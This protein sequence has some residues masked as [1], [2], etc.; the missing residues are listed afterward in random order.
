MSDPLRIRSGG[1]WISTATATQPLKLKMPNGAWRVF[2][3]GTGTPL[4]QKQ[5]DGSWRVVAREGF[6]ADV[7]VPATSYTFQPGNWT[8]ADR[9]LFATANQSGSTFFDTSFLRTS[10]G[11]VYYLLKETGTTNENSQYTT[12]TKRM[13]HGYFDLRQLFDVN[14][15]GQPV[16]FPSL[17]SGVEFPYESWTQVD[18]TVTGTASYYYD[19]KRAVGLNVYD[20]RDPGTDAAWSALEHT[21]TRVD[22]S[23]IP[24]ET[25][26]DDG[27]DWTL[28]TPLY[29]EP[30]GTPLLVVSSGGGPQST[31]VPLQRADLDDDVFAFT[32]TADNRPSDPPT[33]P[34]Y[35]AGWTRWE[36]YSVGGSAGFGVSFTLYWPS[37]TYHST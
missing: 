19:H 2:G 14:T 16:P 26:P 7:V 15:I 24:T 13:T 28:A 20:I 1:S 3:G 9:S 36:E 18:V 35:S 31:V 27:Q 8:V 22:P 37:W 32:V 17:P 29:H 11:G 5:P 21:L 25:V 34:D 6:G 4:Y 23:T 33:D 30:G 10:T 12:G